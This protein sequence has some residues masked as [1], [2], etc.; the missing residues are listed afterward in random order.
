MSSTLMALRAGLQTNTPIMSL[1]SDFSIQIA[2]DAGTAE[3]KREIEKRR[4]II[5]LIHQ[6][7]IDNGILSYSFIST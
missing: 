2:S 5:V 3:Q 4:N 6:H 1:N 7:L